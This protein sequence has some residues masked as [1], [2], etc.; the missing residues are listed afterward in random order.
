MLS[1]SFKGFIKFMLKSE[2][3]SST[4]ILMETLSE[5]YKRKKSDTQMNIGFL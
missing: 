5:L 2:F 1:F 4:T 3:V